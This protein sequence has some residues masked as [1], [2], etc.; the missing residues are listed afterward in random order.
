MFNNFKKHNQFCI[1]IHFVI[2]SDNIIYMSLL[3]IDNFIKHS[4]TEFLDDISLEEIDVTTL[5]Y[6]FN[7]SKRD[8]NFADHSLDEHFSIGFVTLKDVYSLKRYFDN[9]SSQ[10]KLSKGE[11]RDLDS[12]YYKYGALLYAKQNPPIPQIVHVVPI[13]Q[14]PHAVAI[15]GMITDLSFDKLDETMFERI[16]VPRQ[17]NKIKEEILQAITDR[18]FDVLTSVI[19]LQTDVSIFLTRKIDVLLH[20][21]SN[22]DELIQLVNQIALID[23]SVIYRIFNDTRVI[24]PYPARS[25]LDKKPGSVMSSLLIEG[26]ILLYDHVLQIAPDLR[27]NSFDDLSIL[28][29]YVMSSNDISLNIEKPLFVRIVNRLKSN[30]EGDYI[31]IFSVE[32]FENAINALN[33]FL[34]SYLNEKAWFAR[35]VDIQEKTSKMVDMIVASQERYLLDLKIPQIFRGHN[36]WESSTWGREYSFLLNFDATLNI[37]QLHS[38]SAEIFNFTQFGG[39]VAN[40]KYMEKYFKY[41]HKNELLKKLML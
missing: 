13:I 35:I 38:I 14:P 30:L 27:L 32:W 37:A 16:V 11:K 21:A 26:H 31:D 40:T 23:R 18:N 25:Y 17:S 1:L 8:I 3:E 2:I 6:Y 39:Q 29:T 28:F 19:K 33:Q 41:K 22:Q 7:R 34:I 9:Q 15:V 12:I 4:N 10:I 5:R 20:G 24:Y 36:G